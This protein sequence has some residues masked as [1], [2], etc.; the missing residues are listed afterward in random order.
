[1]KN[2]QQENIEP[3]LVKKRRGRKIILWCLGIVLLILLLLIG[4]AL[5]FTAALFDNTPRKIIRNE[6]DYDKLEQIAAKFGIESGDGINNNTASKW[7]EL[8]LQD[9]KIVELSK[10]EM[11][12]LC[13]TSVLS[14]EIYLSNTMPELTITNCQ[15]VNGYFT[16]DCSFESSFSTPFGKY[17]N[18]RIIFLPKILKK[19]LHLKIKSFSVGSIIIKGEQIQELVDE[20][21]KQFENTQN[22]KDLLAVVKTFYVEKEKVT[23]VF[24]PKKAALLLGIKL[25]E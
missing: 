10:E 6:P 25:T 7:I 22:G 18:I 9:I 19:H 2:Q 12:A 15:F 8:L 1:L 24:Y 14:S 13:N 17:L 21:L 4:V 5:W 11:Q 3:K 20:E 23:I 16:V